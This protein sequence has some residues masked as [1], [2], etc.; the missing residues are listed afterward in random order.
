[1]MVL[2]NEDTNKITNGISN[3]RNNYTVTDKADGLP[4]YFIN[5]DG[6]IYLISTTMAV[7]FMTLLVKKSIIQLLMENIY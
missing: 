7:Q 1:M 6:K 5:N 3:I 2:K 4:N